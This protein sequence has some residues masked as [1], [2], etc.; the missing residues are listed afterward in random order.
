[1]HA[2]TTVPADS[3]HLKPYAATR[4]FGYGYQTWIF[5]SERRVFALLGLRGQAVYVDP[6]SQVVLVHTAVRRLPVD[7][8]GEE[9]AALW[10]GIREQ[11]GGTR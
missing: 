11:L 4:S 1:M 10:E 2:A 7:P 3:W 9:L 5:P 6:G 8:G